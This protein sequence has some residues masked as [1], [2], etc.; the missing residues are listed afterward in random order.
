MDGLH[1]PG[2]GRHGARLQRRQ[3]RRRVSWN[4][5]YGPP[6]RRRTRPDDARRR[7]VI[8]GSG[9][10]TT[11]SR[12]GDYTSMN[13]D[14]VDDC[15]FWYVNEYYTAPARGTFTAGADAYAIL[16]AARLQLKTLLVGGA[17][18]LAPPTG[19]LARPEERAPTPRVTANRTP[20]PRGS[21]SF[22]RP[23]SGQ[24]S[25]GFEKPGQPGRTRVLPSP[26]P[27]GEGLGGRP[28]RQRENVH[29]SVHK[30]RQRPALGSEKPRF[31]GSSS[32]PRVGLEPTALR[33]TAG[34]SAN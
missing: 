17:G 25:L 6:R 19:E 12:W 1:R 33:L 27:L 24:D 4:S 22:R 23:P 34:C 16:Q 30:T 9:Q 21:V 8:N 13:I 2:E 5:V 29:K 20:I 7:D 3:R 31:Q 10:R 28:S 32:L 11:N 26:S 14:P 18:S 15:T